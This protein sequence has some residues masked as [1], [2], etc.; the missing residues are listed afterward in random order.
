MKRPATPAPRR[1]AVAA[2]ERGELSGQRDQPPDLSRL[3]DDVA[4]GDARV[5]GVRAQQR[6]EHAHGRG[7]AGAVGP[8]QRHDRSGVDPQ[9]E[10]LDGGEFSKALREAFGFD[11]WYLTHAAKVYS[12]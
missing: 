9:V 4:A 11:R 2:I 12:H 1:G 3:V 5:P 8:E 10:V 7:L 6:R